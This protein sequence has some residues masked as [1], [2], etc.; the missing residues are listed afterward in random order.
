MSDA[1][2]GHE[3]LG[4]G[5]E[6]EEEVSD[7]ET[8]ELSNIRII[9]LHKETQPLGVHLRKAST[10]DGRCVGVGV[11]GEGEAHLFVYM[12]SV[13]HG[14]NGRSPSHSQGCWNLHS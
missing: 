4:G 8:E 10:A 7:G 1:S 6:V 9:E 2:D 14:L 12:C 3:E 5:E 11:L 13:L